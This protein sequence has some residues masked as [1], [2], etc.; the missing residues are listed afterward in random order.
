MTD[1]YSKALSRADEDPD[2]LDSVHKIIKEKALTEEAYAEVFELL[3]STAKPEKER[4]VYYPTEQVW[5]RGNRP[6]SDMKLFAA[7]NQCCE[8]I[9]AYVFYSWH[10]SVFAGWLPRKELTKAEDIMAEME[11]LAH[12]KNIL[13]LAAAKMSATEMPEAESKKI[14]WN[15]KEEGEE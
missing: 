3:F 15:E 5:K 11:S 13:S 6:M 14:D 7:I 2:L 12:S 8:L 9:Y 10:N 1:Y 4:L